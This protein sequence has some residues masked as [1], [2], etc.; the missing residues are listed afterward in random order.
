MKKVL[1]VIF[2]VLLIFPFKT[3][4]GGG[5]MIQWSDVKPLVWKNFKKDESKSSKHKTHSAIGIVIEPE[6]K[7]AQTMVA[8]VYAEFDMEKSSK[9]DPDGQTDD[10]LH[11]EQTRFDL[12]EAYARKERKQLPDSTYK[13]VGKFQQIAQHINKQANK[14]FLEE[15]AK[16]DEETKNGTDDAAQKKWDKDISDRL[17]QLSSYTADDKVELN[18]EKGIPKK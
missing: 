17:T 16:Y 5:D 12:A 3:M 18:I 10:A 11:H 15:S 13:T 9:P 1:A 2:F 7:D 6:E 14:D 8:N 4:L